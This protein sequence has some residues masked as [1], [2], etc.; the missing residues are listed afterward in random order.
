MRHDQSEKLL[1]R[2][3]D[4]ES[5][6]EYSTSRYACDLKGIVT[7]S[8][9]NSLSFTDYPSIYPMPNEGNNTSMISTGVASV[10]SQTSR[11]SSRKTTSTR[12]VVK[13]RMIVF[14][15]GGACYSELRAA[16]EIMEKGGQEVIIGST[17]FVNPSEFTQN[18]SSL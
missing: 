11:Y 2:N 8:Q 9:T 3:I 13:T 17:H 6:I 1:K 5:D 16:N 15:A 12:S 4:A 14:V 18:L 10:R 7:Q